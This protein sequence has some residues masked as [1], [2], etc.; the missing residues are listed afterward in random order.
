MDNTLKLRVMLDMVDNMTKPLQMILT[1]NKGL[2]DSLKA[3]RRELDEMA[4][5]QQRVGEFR[6]MR[7]GLADTAVELKAARA[8]VDALGQS[9]NAS[10]APSRRMIRDLESAKGSASGLAATFGKQADQLR[11]LRGQLADAT[12]DTG[13][14]VQHERELDEV[15]D[16]REK[17]TSKRSLS[18]YGSTMKDV[19]GKMFDVLPGL[20][21]EAKQA[22]IAAA[23]IRLAGGSQA[24][25][26]YAREMNVLGQSIPDNEDLVADL[27]KELGD[28]AHIKLAA[29][30]L[31][32]IK[33]ANAVLLDEKE[34]K[35]DNEVILSLTKVIEQ[36]GGFRNPTAFAAELNAAQKMI[37]STE[38]RVSGEKWNDFAKASG[39]VAKRLRSEVFYYQM[40]PVVHKLG[41]EQAGKG[42]AAL[43]GSAFQEKLS[44]SAVKRMIELDLIDP[45]LVAYKKN[46]TFDKLLPGALRRDD[47]RQ[48]S[49]YEW[50][51]QV[52]QPR[53]KAKGII[54]PDQVTSELARILPDKDARQFLTAVSELNKEIRETAQSGTDAYGVDARYAMAL[55]TTSGRESVVR[56]HASDAKLIPGE[57]LQPSYNAGLDV[58]GTLTEK[59]VKLMQEHGTA[60]SI[61]ATAFAALAGLLKFG[62]PVLQHFP[63]SL[64]KS[65]MTR[66]ATMGADALPSIGAV[67]ARVIPLAVKHPVI[68]L[69][70]GAAALAGGIAL[71]KSAGADKSS[72]IGELFDGLSPNLRK[73]GSD[74]PASP[75]DTI[76]N[77]LNA[78]VRLPSMPLDWF[79]GASGIGD[80][81]PARP[82]GSPVNAPSILAMLGT[83]VAS[84]IST[85]ALAANMPAAGALPTG[86]RAP[87]TAPGGAASAPPP[88]PAPITINIT[89]PP[90]VNAA[91]LARLVRVELERAERARTS[92]AGSR[93]SD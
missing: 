22:E 42:L 26:N 58:A 36:R 5:T 64:G 88:V 15:I 52:L 30:A 39:D 92:R 62:G 13:K 43:S 76:L 35:A 51:E 31:S 18:E 33:L 44:A 29:P 8:H 83:A 81:I 40:E 89:P 56:A 54:R 85:P 69:G 10:S 91:E 74:A 86:N 82:F 27:Q 2:A 1:G 57:K 19:G 14:L 63:T 34:A 71:S 60:T 20:L 50:F 70:L 32:K 53:L 79:P 80:M 48:T 68:A 3:S 93:L 65:V 45:K 73:P 87:I 77:R 46:G 61:F 23:R 72:G 84:L 25:V 78:L 24:L 16:R 67:A 38:G 28:E 90:G 7:R 21:D 59:A 6:E 47:L 41:G 66:V 49:P 9:L 75:G 17:K 4:K 12:A 11:K 55:Q 37:W